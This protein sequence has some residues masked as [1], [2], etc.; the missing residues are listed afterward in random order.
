[1]I[2]HVLRLV[3]NRKRSNL[4]LTA[5]IAISFLVLFGVVLAA[6]FYAD[7][8]RTPNGFDTGDVWL[9][10]VDVKQQSDDFW[11]ETMVTKMHQ[12]E[13]AIHDLP[14]AE[15]SAGAFSA[16]Y[17]TNYSMSAIDTR[18]G[19]GEYYE[20]DE[21]TDAFADVLRMS[22]TRGRFF[23]REDDAASVPPVVINERLARALFG[24]EDAVGRVLNENDDSD[25]MRVVGVVSDYKRD[26]EYSR[27]GYI[28]FKRAKLDD[29]KRRPPRN[30]VVRTRPG[31][32]ADFEPKLARTLQ[33]TAPDWSFE[34]KPLDEL[35]DRWNR[36]MLAPLVTV[37]LVAAFLMLMVGLGL[38]GVLWQSV[39][40]RTQEIG[41]RRVQ[42]ATA[43]DIC[44]QFLGELLVVCTFGLVIGAL[45]VVQAPLLGLT[46]T[47]GGGVF[48]SSMVIAAGLIYLLT[49]A[50]GF[51]PSW[52]A[53][54]VEPVHALRYE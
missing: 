22:V 40:N 54:R 24:D 46:G 29:P 48:A 9:V 35:R 21:V 39:T 37:G 3:W 50:C 12:L 30:F 5:E 20:Q 47:I 51:Y 6:T 13:L 4:L 53:T 1:M 44:M 49:A 36:A 8:Y 42:G 7:N 15:V 27:G 17:L 43:G 52:M 26:G 14:E 32:P 41:L 19:P 18:N 10:S 11:D 33:A 34:V 23:T 16:P 31:T 45:V 25:R 38:M 2:R 28:V